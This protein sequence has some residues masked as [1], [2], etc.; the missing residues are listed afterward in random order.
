MKQTGYIKLFFLNL[1]VWHQVWLGMYPQPDWFFF[2]KN[3][4]VTYGNNS[5]KENVNKSSPTKGVWMK[6]FGMLG[7]FKKPHQDLC[8]YFITY[9]C[10]VR[11]KMEKSRKNLNNGYLPLS[12]SNEKE[13]EE[14]TT[15]LNQNYFFLQVLIIFNTYLFDLLSYWLFFKIYY[16]KNTIRY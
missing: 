8:K 14:E 1:L 11:M 5:Q 10:N 6:K 9:L 7:R 3:D 13:R 15:N 16:N 12:Q 4:F 2:F